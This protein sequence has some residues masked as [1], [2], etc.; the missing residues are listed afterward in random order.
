MTFCPKVVIGWDV[1][2]PK[3][4]FRGSVVP[5]RMWNNT[6][7]F[8]G[9]HLL[10]PLLIDFFPRNSRKSRVHNEK[11]S[12]HGFL[13]CKKKN[14]ILFTNFSSIPKSFSP[15]KKTHQFYS[16]AYYSK[17][18]AKVIKRLELLWQSVSLALLLV[19]PKAFWVH[20]S[21]SITHNAR[22]KHTEMHANTARNRVHY[23]F[24]G[25]LEQ[26]QRCE[27]FMDYFTLW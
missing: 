9:S 17:V 26:K 25:L 24:P 12:F 19:S 27:G 2:V 10:V 18:A 11:T 4:F 20:E 13:F 7:V 23:L 3:F 5:K 8:V 14:Q 16:K 1:R 15:S 22:R 21:L 6:L